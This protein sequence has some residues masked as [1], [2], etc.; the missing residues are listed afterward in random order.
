MMARVK[1]LPLLLLLLLAAAALVYA[2]EQAATEKAMAKIVTFKDKG[3][4]NVRGERR[5][6]LAA[7]GVLDQKIK[8]FDNQE[9]LAVVAGDEDVETITL[10]VQDKDGKVLAAGEGTGPLACVTYKPAKMD[11]YTFK[12]EVPKKG[13]Y[14]HFS[15]VTK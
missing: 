15:L 12:V 10:Q 7:A 14:Y 1:R 4:V 6:Y 2:S 9:Y 5:G 13:G 8:M 3:F 11:K